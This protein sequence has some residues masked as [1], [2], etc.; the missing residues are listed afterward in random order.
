MAFLD[1]TTLT[2]LLQEY[3]DRPGPQEGKTWRTVLV[4]GLLQR[5][6]DGDLKAI[7]EVWS[8]MDGKPGEAIQ[9][10][11]LAIDDALARKVLLAAYDEE[12][13]PPDPWRGPRSLAQG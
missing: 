8:R 12:D 7:Q 3:L 10:I 13:D 6:A 4:E 2:G 1:A 5:A 11:P 9:D